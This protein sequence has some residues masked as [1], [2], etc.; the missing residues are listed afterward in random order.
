MGLSTQVRSLHLSSCTLQLYEWSRWFVVVHTA[1]AHPTA[2]GLSTQVHSLQDFMD[3]IR[4]NS[5]RTGG[6]NSTRT[7]MLVPHI[8]A[9][10]ECSQNCR[11][12]RQ[13]YYYY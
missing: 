5:T 2:M 9:V 8:H 4:G 12:S 13:Y 3:G 1:C 7:S 10:F 6:A 11:P